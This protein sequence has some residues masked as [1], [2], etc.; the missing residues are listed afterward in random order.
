MPGPVTSTPMCRKSGNHG[1]GDDLRFFAI[2]ENPVS[3]VVT[4]YPLLDCDEY[5][6]ER[7]R[8]DVEDAVRCAFR[9]NQDWGVSQV[10]PRSRFSLSQ[11]DRELHELLADLRSVEFNRAEDI[12]SGLSLPVLASLSVRFGSEP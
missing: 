9:E 12:V 7:V 11:L 5:R 2:P 1:H 8:Q 3:L 4:V 6:R 10:Y